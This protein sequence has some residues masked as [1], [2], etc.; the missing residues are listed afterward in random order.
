MVIKIIA[1]GSRGRDIS[2]DKSPCEYDLASVSLSR[3]FRIRL[4]VVVTLVWGAIA[5]APFIP[6]FPQDVGYHNFADQRPFLSVPNALN[7]LSNLP[8]VFVGVWGLWFVGRADGQI[9]AGRW[10]R[11]AFGLLFAFV[12]L[13][14]VGSSYY[15]WQP[16]NATL[17][18]DRL[19]LTVVF[20]AFFA[21]ILG[22]RIKWESCRL[23]A[24]P[25][26]GGRR[27]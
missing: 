27:G 9:F 7:V 23:A 13:T 15:H 16:G 20:M 14:G 10:E 2:I 25:A 3:A 11:L 6:P 21:I 5:A 8:F 18:W 22:E 1:C 26:A 24:R 17:Y 12:A 4:L 19:P